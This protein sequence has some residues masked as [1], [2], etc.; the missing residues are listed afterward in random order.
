MLL[1]SVAKW[2][3]YKIG[4]IQQKEGQEESEDYS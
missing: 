4:R 2:G 1:M 3:V